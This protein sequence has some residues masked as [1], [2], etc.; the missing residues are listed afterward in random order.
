MPMSVKHKL[1]EF[2]HKWYFLPAVGV[3]FIIIFNLGIF[4]VLAWSKR[5][6]ENQNQEVTA[7]PTPSP[8]ASATPE[9]EYTPDPGLHQNP[10]P[11]PKPS[12]SVRPSPTPNPSPTPSPT[13][14]PYPKEDVRINNPKHQTNYDS[15]EIEISMDVMANS[16]VEKLEVLVNGEVKHT[17]SSKPYTIKLNLGAGKYDLQ[18]RARLSSD[19]TISSG[20]LK[21]GLGGTKWDDPDPT[22]TPS[23]TPNPTPTPSPSPTPT[24]NED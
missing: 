8:I 3:V 24:P 17:F 20:V 19:K 16:Q 18:G 5:S 6:S 7:S 9:P 21:F 22:P 13:A 10:T 14:T 2:S 23:P 11:S 15:S 1:K 4:S 12:P